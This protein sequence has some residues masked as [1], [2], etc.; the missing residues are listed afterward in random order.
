VKKTH[1]FDKIRKKLLDL[2]PE[3]LDKHFHKFHEEVIAEIDCMDCAACCKTISPAMRDADLLRMV[4]PLK[5]KPS[6][7]FETYMN[8]DAEGD[9]VFIS[10]P[11]PFLAY[12]NACSIYEHRPGAC[13]EYPHTNRVQMHRILELTFRNASVC[14]AV[15]EIIIRIDSIQD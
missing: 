1:G 7:I 9:Y 8:R 13:R 6:E 11:C 3:I 5:M 12:D 2:K 10:S 14:P 15:K 4:K